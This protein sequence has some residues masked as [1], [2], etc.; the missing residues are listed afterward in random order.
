MNL[1]TGNL[2]P[3]FL[4]FGFLLS[5]SGMAFNAKNNFFLVTRFCWQMNSRAARMI[6]SG[7]SILFGFISSTDGESAGFADECKIL[8]KG[9]SGRREARASS[10]ASGFTCFHA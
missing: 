2:T 7:R 5:S 3:L 4:N 6:L 1:V 9:G 10:S 8:G